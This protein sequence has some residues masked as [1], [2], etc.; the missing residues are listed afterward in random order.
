MKI[1]VRGILTFVLLS[2]EHLRTLGDGQAESG[3]EL[4]AL[5]ALLSMGY[6][7]PFQGPAWLR[8]DSKIAYCSKWKE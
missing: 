5:P 3:S 8:P 1:S 4:L 7:P 6:S 2:E